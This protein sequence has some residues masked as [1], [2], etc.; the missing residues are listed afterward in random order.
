MGK[1]FGPRCM[2]ISQIQTLLVALAAL[3]PRVVIIGPE[4]VY[5]ND[6]TPSM[7]ALC[8]VA[9]MIL[10]S[11]ASRIA[12]IALDTGMVPCTYAIV[13]RIN[14]SGYPCVLITLYG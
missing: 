5:N 1:S 3:T 14:V 2:S 9:E 7:A 4:E 8:V 11:T 10:Q 12:S 13:R 6:V